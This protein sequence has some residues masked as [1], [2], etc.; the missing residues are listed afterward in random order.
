MQ[1]ALEHA[2]GSLMHYRHTHAL[3]EPEAALFLSAVR[4]AQDVLLPYLSSCF[5]RIFPGARLDTSSTQQLL[6]SVLQDG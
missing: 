2:A 1:Q 5:A 4:V 6:L 3:P